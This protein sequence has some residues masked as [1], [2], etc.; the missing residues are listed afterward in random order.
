MDGCDLSNAIGK[1][2][3]FSLCALVNVHLHQFTS[4]FIYKLEYNFPP[5]V[6]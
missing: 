4:I 2:D 3:K 5:Y 6:K 1:H